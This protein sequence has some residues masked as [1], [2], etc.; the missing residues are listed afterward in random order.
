[1]T[2]NIHLSPFKF[3]ITRI[4]LSLLDSGRLFALA[5]INRYIFKWNWRLSYFYLCLEGGII[6]AKKKLESTRKVS[7][8]KSDLILL[9]FQNLSDKSCLINI[10]L[11]LLRPFLKLPKKARRMK[12]TQCWEW[13]NVSFQNHKSLYTKLIYAF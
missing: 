10:Y 8:R 1:M 13:R 3:K 4:Y 6:S 2:V 7:R 9:L 12:S 11:D 5:R